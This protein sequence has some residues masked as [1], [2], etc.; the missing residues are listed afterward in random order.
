MEV[1]VY[2]SILDIDGKLW[3]SIVPEGRIICSHSYLKLIEKSGLNE[4]Q[5]YYLTVAAN[6]E[7]YAHTWAYLMTAGVDLFAQGALKGLINAVRRVWKDFLVMRYIECGSPVTTGDPISVKSGCDRAK[8]LDMLCGGIE[9]LA[10][11]LKV[12]TVLLRDFTEDEADLRDIFLKRGYRV[13]HNLPKA[14]L[15]VRWRGFAQY[16]DAMRS[17]YRR[18]IEKR[19]DKCSGGVS[20][21]VRALAGLPYGAEDLKRLHDNILEHAKEVRREGPGAYF[22]ENIAACLQDRVSVVIAEKSG[23]LIGFM[24][25]LKNQDEL[26]AS[27]MGL[28]YS[29]NE[30]HFVYFNIFYRAIEYGIE[31]GM[32]KINLSVTSL[33]TKKDM[34]ADIVKLDMFV[35]HSNGAMTALIST[36]F[37]MIMPPDTTGPRNVFK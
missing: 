23:T 37:D 31:N 24:L 18:K 28:D 10:A 2:R 6:G 17:N 13:M 9:D 25:L 15:R 11:R 19:I 21:S 14:E 32:K 30:E 34:G 20:V 16:L 33:D 3:D 8:I 1:K 29:C 12:K 36:L 4:G 27:T 7:L 22:F 5:S 26:M 35:K